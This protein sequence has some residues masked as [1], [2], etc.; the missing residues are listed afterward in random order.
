MGTAG[1]QAFEPVE[2]YSPGDVEFLRGQHLK[3][4]TTESKFVDELFVHSFVKNQDSGYG[5]TAEQVWSFEEIQGKRYH[6]RR[7][8][9]RN[10]KGDKLEKVRL[11]YDYTGPVEDSKAVE[12]E[13]DDGLAYGDDS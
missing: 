9:V 12:N 13:E 5:W 11:V 7:V 3:N 4:G 10:A 1:I 2:V 8:V 6:T